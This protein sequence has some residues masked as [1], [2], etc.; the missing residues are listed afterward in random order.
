MA[1]F[2][3]LSARFEEE[4]RRVAV[5]DSPFV[6]ETATHLIAA[7]GK[8]FRPMLVFLASRFGGEA[9][10]E[11]LLKAAMVME[12]THVA[13]LYHDDVMDEAEVRRAA[14]SANSRWG[15]SIA[16]LAGDYLFAKAS[17]LVAD[18]GTEYVRLQAETFTRLVQGQINETRGPADGEDRLEHHV[19][20]LADKTGSL[21]AASALFG[22]MVAGAPVDAQQALAAYGEEVGLV[23]QL[24]DDIIDITSD[25]TGKTP[26][27][28]LREG[29]PTLPTLLL[30]ASDDPQDAELKQLLAGDLSSDEA[31]AAAVAALR[32][33]RVI[34][35]ARAEVRRRAELA[36]AHL[37]PL[38]EG[39]AKELLIKV[40]DDLVTRSA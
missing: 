39:E 13:S 5:A 37:A 25:V 38:P 12:L 23:F 15:N 7:G 11:R 18:L 1:E 8:R 14:P 33:H 35:E 3:A 30:A 10:E 28:D 9:D 34:E 21:I 20:V 24:S 17:I 29:V 31:L 6:T 19:Q 40:C 36:K 26:G 32:S 27:T 16:I 22:A 2:E 4:L